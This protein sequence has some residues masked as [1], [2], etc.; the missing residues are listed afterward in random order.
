MIHEQNIA[1]MDPARIGWFRLLLYR[2]AVGWMM[3]VAACPVWSAATPGGDAAALERSVKAAFLYKFV[4]YVEWPDSAFAR[5]DAPITIAVMG[6]DQFADELAKLVSGR[7]AEG[8]TLTVRKQKDDNLPDDTHILFI[9]R[10][11]T[12]ARLR[13]SAKI[14]RPILIVTESEGALTQGSAINFLV[15][16]GRVRFEVALEAAEKR[17]IRLS[18]R[19]LTVAQNVR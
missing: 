6:D 3:M 9:A 18:S 17:G 12:A 5:A 14:S 8:R 10:A 11:E 7:S 16:G 13:A 4:G 19:L 1:T 15:T 2:L